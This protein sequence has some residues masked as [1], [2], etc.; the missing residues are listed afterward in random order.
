MASSL[1]ANYAG[2]PVQE[3]IPGALDMSDMKVSSILQ[4]RRRIRFQPQTGVSA[5]PQEIIQ[6]VLSDSTGL[7]DVNSMV[8]SFTPVVTGA[9]SLASGKVCCLDDGP[10][11]IRRVQVLANGSLIEDIDNSHRAANIELLSS[12]GKEWYAHDGSF[13]NYWRLNETLGNKNA[14]ANSAC[15]NDALDHGY[16][17]SLDL[18]GAA[19]QMAIPMGLIAPSLRSQRYWPL[20]N[21]G[22]LVLQLTTSAATEAIFNTGGGSPSYNLYDIFLEV[23][24]I[25]PIPQFAALLDR[26]TQLQ[27]EPG[28]VIPVE[29]KL[30][31]QGQSI[32]AAATAGASG[33]L[34]ESNIVTSRATT[35]LRRV[36]LAVQPTAGLNSYTYPSVSNYPDEGFSSVQWRVG[37]LYF[38]QQPANSLAR[39]WAMTS[40]AYGEVANTDRSAV[41][42][43]HN[44]DTTTL[45][46]T[47]VAYVNR[48]GVANGQFN[49]VVVAAGNNRFTYADFAPKSYC[50][51]SYK[52]G[53][54]LDADGISVLGQAGSQIV[55]ILRMANPEDVTP[56]VCLTATKY[57]VLKDGG[58]R[59][60]GT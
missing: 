37:S 42:N 51:D 1:H 27:S 18:S 34:T 29:T 53:Q 32:Q 6:F 19:F 33:T 17:N 54:E 12:V 46:S 23:D 58:L 48:P 21:M 39:A 2:L 50:F 49:G 26:M 3:A 13:M 11:M 14:S 38:P 25:T 59:V 28:L 60:Q 16:F 22:E 47:G 15:Q 24:I 45:Y 20:R 41:Y 44:F 57:L 31:S 30:V 43:R 7:M 4:G 52:G 55:N 56:I 35:N 8:L 5:G 9:P 40:A 10:S 36:D